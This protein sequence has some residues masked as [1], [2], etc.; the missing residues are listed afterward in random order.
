MSQL[1][2]PPLSKTPSRDTDPEIISIKQLLRLLDRMAK[3]S[4]TY[5]AHNS[6]A[7]KFFSQFNEELITHLG[8]YQTMGFL[9][10]RS[11]LFSKDQ[12]VY[13]TEEALGENLAFRL[14][15]DGIRELVFHDGITPEDVRAFLD[16][17]WGIADGSDADDD[18]V[19]RI[20]SKNL[21]TITVVSAEEIVKAHS[22]SDALEIKETGFFGAAPT[23]FREVAAREK[24]Q[25]GGGGKGAGT[26]TA[27]LGMVGYEI[28]E[29][30]MAALAAEIKAESSMDHALHVLEMV[31]AILASEQSPLL[32]A[33][34]IEIFGGV[35]DALL[36]S[37]GWTTLIEVLALLR[38]MAGLSDVLTDVHKVQISDILNSI[39][40]PERIKLVEGALNRGPEVS[41]EGLLDYLSQLPT[42][43][44][45]ALCSV[46]GNLQT[47]DHRTVLAQVLAELAKTDPEP[48]VK[49]L[50]DKRP[51]LVKALLGILVKL[52]D[53]RFGDAIE[54]LVRYPDPTVRR[55]VLRAL[56]QL[57]PNGNATKLVTFVSDEDEMIR[58]NALKLLSSGSYTVSFDVW[59]P[60]IGQEQFIDRTPADKRAIFHAIRAT[61]GDAAVPYWRGLLADWGWTGRQKKEDLALLAIDSLAR[62]G[63]PAA[64]DALEYGQRKGNST[65]RQA[66]A[67]ALSAPPRSRT[68]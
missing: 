37:G 42:D 58:L 5:G 35:I 13:S 14:Y 8:T 38:E 63:T 56:S 55:E 10:Q 15:S 32:L 20:W 52:G 49:S 24:A 62:L 60:I 39:A 40:K 30:E 25:M 26:R 22:Q 51:H 21:T 19:T 61:A 47:P 50:T 29:E 12:V 65:V 36:R 3:S 27:N 1:A 59:A 48:I 16:A 67:T 66:C 46:L 4:R 17:L 9:V 2:S 54:K 64:S 34:T 45:P 11:E 53:A 28:S 44:M 68:A 31:K 7:V 57:R 43:A 18:I 6:V 33:R 41:T 23:S